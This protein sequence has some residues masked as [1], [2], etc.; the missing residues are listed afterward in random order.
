MTLLPT[1][2]ASGVRFIR[3]YIWSGWG[4]LSTLILSVWSLKKIGA[5]NHLLLRSNKYLASR[6]RHRLRALWNGAEDRSSRWR[7][8][9]GARPGVGVLLG[10]MLLL[11]LAWQYSSS[12]L[13]N[14]SLVY[15]GLK[16][17][18]VSSFQS[19][20]KSII[21]SVE[22]TLLLLLIDIHIIW[23][24]AGKLRET[25]D[26]L[27]QCHGSLLQILELLLELDN[28]LRYVM[29]S[30]SH[31]ELIPVDGVRFFTSFY[32]CIPPISYRSYQLMQ[33]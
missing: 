5:R 8:D 26:V 4:S 2:E 9:I 22:E 14:K 27:T 19:I 1:V 16:I 33:S 29:R 31:L 23:S 3:C 32:I 17:L 10:L 30:E 7:T 11:A 28:T 6:L 13:E 12:V 15:H 21:Q 20:G 24:I 25:G 18:E